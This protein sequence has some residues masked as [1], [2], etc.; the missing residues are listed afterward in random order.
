MILIIFRYSYVKLKQEFFYNFL[1]NCYAS[2][3]L[4][5]VN[6]KCL[7]FLKSLIVTRNCIT[8]LNLLLV[9]LSMRM[10]LILEGKH[11]TNST[12]V[13]CSYER[14]TQ[15]NLEDQITNIL[16]FLISIVCMP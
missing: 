13:A 12:H 11:V 3:L 2:F 1:I 15:Y 16:G 6:I 7:D 10:K 14:M 8:R 9:K 5:S 4:F